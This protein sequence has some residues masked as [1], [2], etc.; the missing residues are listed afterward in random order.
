MS[1]VTPDEDGPIAALVA[2]AVLVLL[3]ALARWASVDVLIGIALGGAIGC[4]I[5]AYR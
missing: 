3:I 2:A 5:R 4:L 1:P